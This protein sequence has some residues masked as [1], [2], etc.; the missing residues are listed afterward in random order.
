MNVFDFNKIKAYP[1]AE[2]NKNILY[3]QS[4]FKVRIIELPPDGE[5]PTCKMDSYVI[6]YVIKGEVDIDI[7][8]ENK[9]LSEGHCLIT[10]P[11]T[12]SMRTRNGAK[13]LGV[14]I[15]QQ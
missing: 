11:A 13:I 4:N 15:T 2:R 5:M 7:N 8:Q 3:S 10:E 1:Y 9:I 14:Q 6:F 12:L